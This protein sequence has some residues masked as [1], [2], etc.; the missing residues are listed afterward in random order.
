MNDESPAIRPAT[1][2]DLPRIVAAADRVFRHPLRPGLGSMGRDYPL[3]FEPANASNLWLAESR[4]G[5]LLAHVGFVLRGANVS[6]RPLKVACFGAVFTQPEHRG[7]GLASQVFSAATAHARSLGADLALVSGA[8]GLY[9]RAGFSD[10]PPCLRYRVSA[11]PDHPP[12]PPSSPPSSSAPVR[13]VPYG[14]S[15]LADMMALQ[16]AEP[17]RFERS[18]DDWNR[19]LATGILFFSPA[20]VFVMER[21]GRRIA[22]AAVA[23]LTPSEA[24]LPTGRT[25]E[26]AGDRQAIAEA[27][28]TLMR[29]LGLGGLEVVLPPHD[30]SLEASARALGWQREEIRF[31]FSAAWWNPTHAGL[32]L[33]FYGLNYV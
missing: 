11:G 33:P 13:P 16:A 30:Q 20:H 3:L 10:Y 12:S 19:L 21:E 29:S 8:R 32:P 26:V 6:G 25:L 14:P 27:A 22:Y 15:A 24:A 9:L 17:V 1:A 23:T 5:E 18:L 28:P 4:S 7:R 2:A 31:P